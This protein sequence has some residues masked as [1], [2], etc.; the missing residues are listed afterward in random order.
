MLNNKTILLATLKNVKTG[1]N[2][3]RLGVTQTWG[4][5]LNEVI[6]SVFIELGPVHMGR[7]LMT[8]EISVTEIIFIPYEHNFPA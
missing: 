5:Y 4:F 2:L 3:R 8:G 7:S 6:L 1:V